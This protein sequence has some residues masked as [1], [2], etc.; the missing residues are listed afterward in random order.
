MKL[1]L[2]G[3][4]AGAQREAAIARGFR[5]CGVEVRECPYG[6]LIYSGKLLHRVQFRFAVG[7]VHGQITARVI[8]HAREWTPDVIF[9]RR[10]LE[11]SPAMLQTIKR[12]CDALLVSFN[13]DDPFSPAYS[14]RRW[15]LLR[16]A[17]PLFDVHFAFRQRNIEQYRKAGARVV[18]LWEPFYSPW[19]HRPLA[20]ANTS[21]E[22]ASTALFAM[23]AER[24]KRREAVMTLLSA[25]VEVRVRSW[26]WT[27]LF[28]AE[29]K[30]AI[31]PPVWGD[32]YAREV[33][34]ALVTL[35]FFS[36]QNGDELTS[37]VFEVP[38]CGGILAAPVNARLSQLF[39]DG[40]EAILFKDLPDLAK[41][42][43]ALRSSPVERLAMRAAGLRRVREDGHSVVARCAEA[44]RVMRNARPRQGADSQPC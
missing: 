8:S 9:F 38:A 11:F 17:I 28:G 3:P 42:V 21:S 30:I 2:V 12:A 31:L 43:I 37:R 29:E 24:D 35:C 1:L 6:D 7:P 26:N 19:L 14:D 22:L 27:R 18:A 15:R 16:E 44:I 39:R 23:H 34:E 5:E 25:G 20:D 41:R 10:P 40:E 36:A 13:N 4:F 32:D 33:G